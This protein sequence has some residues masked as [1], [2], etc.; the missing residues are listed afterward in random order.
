MYQYRKHLRS[1]FLNYIIAIPIFLSFVFLGV[2]GAI[3]SDGTK[4]ID[5]DFVFLGGLA[6]KGFIFLL[7]YFAVLYFLFLRRFKYI[8]VTLTEDVIVYNNIKKKIVIPYDE[9]IQIKYPSIRYTGG[10]MEIKHTKGKI[11]LTVVLENIG[12]FMYRLKEILDERGK[13]DVYNEKKSLNFFKTASFSDESWG[14]LYDNFKYIIIMEYVSAIISIIFA[15]LGIA[16]NPMF[17]IGGSIFAPIIGYLIIEFILGRNVKKRL[18]TN[19]F[20]LLDRDPNK[21]NKKIR[22]AIIA[23]ILLYIFLIIII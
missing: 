19:E 17:I 20:K 4:L 23:S 15:F 13:S 18:I 10:W 11:R 14:R 3:L 9:I 7:I 16:K 22:I 1:S 6:L 21:E 5:I 2:F 8:N 12:D